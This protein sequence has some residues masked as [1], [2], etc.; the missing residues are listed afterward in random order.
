MSQPDHCLAK[1]SRAR[2]KPLNE[3][4]TFTSCPLPVLKVISPMDDNARHLSS[5]WS[6]ICKLAKQ[7]VGRQRV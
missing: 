7:P 2:A 3:I 1:S 5:T 6:V 4:G